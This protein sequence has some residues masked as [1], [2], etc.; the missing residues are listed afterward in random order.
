[1]AWL[2]SKP[3]IEVR[4][5]DAIKKTLEEITTR[6]QHRLANNI[7]HI[8]W[9]TDEVKA[10]A[11]HKVE[12]ITPKLGYPTQSP[13]L[14]DP[15]SIRDYYTGL[16]ISDSYFDNGVSYS[17]WFSKKSASLIGTQREEGAW[18]AEAGSALTINAFYTGQ[19]NAIIIIAGTL[20]GR[21]LRRAGGRGATGGTASPRPGSASGS[22]CLVEQYGGQQ[23]HGRGRR[24]AAA[25]STA[26]LTLG[27]NIADAWRD[28]R[29]GGPGQLFFVAASQIFCDES[30]GIGM[31]A[32]AAD[33]HSPPAVRIKS[34]MENSRGFREAFNCHV[35]EP[36]CVIY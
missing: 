23:H 13:N 21:A 24:A 31:A 12:S 17:K 22:R 32:Y 4:Y 7:N 34:M 16:D 33:V 14:D 8:E 15:E 1:M 3:F 20:N 28:E 36:T 11:K 6:I 25:P 30:N 19:E 10:I 18:G 9:M 26:R 5:T 2:L 27:E 35:K 29:R